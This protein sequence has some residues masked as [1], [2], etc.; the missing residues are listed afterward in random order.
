MWVERR[1]IF[2]SI[3][4]KRWQG[5]ATVYLSDCPSCSSP[6][7]LG[8]AV[9]SMV[10]AVC[11]HRDGTVYNSIMGRVTSTGSGGEQEEGRGKERAS[12][13]ER[14]REREGGWE[15]GEREGGE[16]EGGREVQIRRQT[17]A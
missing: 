17:L 11:G 1:G 5:L 3:S 4:K 2:V 8:L 13:R 10:T 14:E 15:G 16:G 7:Y 6:S 9:R 12:E